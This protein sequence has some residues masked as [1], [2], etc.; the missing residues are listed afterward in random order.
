[1]KRKLFVLVFG[2]ILINSLSTYADS[3]NIE[4]ALISKARIA[5]RQ[6]DE[7]MNQARALQSAAP[8][9]PAPTKTE[10]QA[11]KAKAAEAKE[12]YNAQ[13]EARRAVFQK[14]KESWMKLQERKEEEALAREEWYSYRN[15]VPPD[16][17]R[18][19]TTAKKAFE[20]AVAALRNAETKHNEMSSKIESFDREILKLEAAWNQLRQEARQAEKTRWTATDSPL[21]DTARDVQSKT[22]YKEA[23]E[24][25]ERAKEYALDAHR[26]ITR[27]AEK[28]NQD[29]ATAK[30]EFIQADRLWFEANRAYS[31][32]LFAHPFNERRT[33]ELNKKM[34]AAEKKRLEA[35]KR[36]QAASEKA[37]ALQAVAKLRECVA[38]IAEAGQK[39]SLSFSP[40]GSSS[41]P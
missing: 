37:T 40:S 6:G 5:L 28:L 15:K 9:Q 41:R 7:A 18:E 1:M 30:A 38:L 19:A 23:R 3:A 35:Q 21:R 20:N 32:S 12:K 26:E 2:L 4:D 17:S 34:M 39:L 24:A 22:F 13:V 31:S 33:K 27:K 29:F 25:Y 14:Y 11:L 10:V 8:A 36:Q 16:L